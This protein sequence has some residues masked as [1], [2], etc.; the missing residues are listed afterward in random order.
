MMAS[1]MPSNVPYNEGNRKAGTKPQEELESGSY[2]AL[3]SSA[4]H[5]TLVHQDVYDTRCR[6]CGKLHFVVIPSTEN[7]FEDIVRNDVH[8]DVMSDNFTN[9]GSLSRLSVRLWG[10]FLGQVGS[11]FEER[12]RHRI[13]SRKCGDLD[14]GRMYR[15]IAGRPDEIQATRRTNY[16]HGVPKVLPPIGGVSRQCGR[17]GGRKPG[18]NFALTSFEGIS[19]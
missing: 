8:L 12:T 10:R 6:D 9:R 19:I 17:A 5:G 1:R 2:R 3:D 13:G 16:R 7:V 18:S 4:E 11:A 15:A 14:S